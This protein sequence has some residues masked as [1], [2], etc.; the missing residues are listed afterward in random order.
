MKEGMKKPL[1]YLGVPIKDTDGKIIG[2]MGV[3]D[4]RPMP[5]KAEGP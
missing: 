2:N 5:E 1:S 3:L 4:S